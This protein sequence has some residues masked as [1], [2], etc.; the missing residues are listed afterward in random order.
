MSGDKN[1]SLADVWASRYDDRDA[2]DL[3]TDRWALRLA[4]R[5][6]AMA[7]PFSN[8]EMPPEGPDNVDLRA[9]ANDARPDSK[10]AA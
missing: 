5:D 2:D 3:L 6:K 7:Q 8:F 4:M 9:A 1:E 10:P